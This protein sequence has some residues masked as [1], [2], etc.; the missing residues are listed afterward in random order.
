MLL[1]AGMAV[2]HGNDSSSVLLCAIQ[3]QAGVTREEP[4]VRN[5]QSPSSMLGELLGVNY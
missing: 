4:V 1:V 3:C 5:Q 2:K